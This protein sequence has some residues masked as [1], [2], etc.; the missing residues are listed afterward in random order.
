MWPPWVTRSCLTPDM[1]MHSW[2]LDRRFSLLSPIHLHLGIIINRNPRLHK[3]SWPRGWILEPAG[4]E[5]LSSAFRRL[6]SVNKCQVS[7]ARHNALCYNGV[8]VWSN[9]CNKYRDV[10]TANVMHETLSS[11]YILNY[12]LFTENF[13]IC[14]WPQLLI[15]S[16]CWL[17]VK[18]SKQV[19]RTIQ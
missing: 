2:R 18:I 6:A 12:F 14:A 15:V 9:V 17:K 3:T 4:R 19:L 13:K 16:C 7:W 11:L 8:I 5:Q 1:A 10:K